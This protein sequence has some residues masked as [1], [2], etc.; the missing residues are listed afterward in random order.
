MRDRVRRRGFELR[1]GQNTRE[2]SMRGEDIGGI[3]VHIAARAVDIAG[4]G[5]LVVTSTVRARV[6]GSGITFDDGTEHNLKG[7]P[8]PWRLFTVTSRH[9]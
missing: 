4:P 6:V 5:A 1:A 3:A 9:P 7:I 2:I 8:E